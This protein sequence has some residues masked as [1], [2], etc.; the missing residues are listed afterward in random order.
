MRVI[1]DWEILAKDFDRTRVME[2][3]LKGT[4]RSNKTALIFPA[5]FE[6]FMFQM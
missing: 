4:Q 6:C 1:I 3:R 2:S 5:P